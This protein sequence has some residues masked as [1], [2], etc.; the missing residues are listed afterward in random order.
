M[1]QHDI[2]HILSSFALLKQKIDTTEEMSLT[3][4]E[5]VTG[6]SLSCPSVCLGVCSP[7]A[8]QEIYVYQISCSFSA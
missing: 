5:K 2:W 4:H 7:H 6:V 3:V 1:V 8:S